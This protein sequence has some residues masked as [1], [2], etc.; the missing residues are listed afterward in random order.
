VATPVAVIGETDAAVQV[1]AAIALVGRAMLLLVYIAA[2]NTAA[3][4][5]TVPS[6]LFMKQAVN[7]TAAPI[8]AIHVLLFR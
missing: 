3:S 4:T 2:L 1:L 5:G 7:T 6:V 8:R